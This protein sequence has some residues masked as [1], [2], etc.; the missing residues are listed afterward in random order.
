M[1]KKGKKVKYVKI[2]IPDEPEMLEIKLRLGK[3]LIEDIADELD[4]STSMVKSYRREI[5]NNID[6]SEKEIILGLEAD[7]KNLRKKILAGK[8]K[9]RPRNHTFGVEGLIRG[10]VRDLTNAGKSIRQITEQTGLETST[11]SFHRKNIKEKVKRKYP[12]RIM[13]MTPA[14]IT[15]EKIK[16][17]LKEGKN[18]TQ[19]CEILNISSA[20]ASTHVKKIREKV[21]I[22]MSNA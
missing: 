9:S 5:L 21:R 6:K 3:M 17:L 19:I 12:P 11:I 8:L 4:L 20:T 14:K 7:I 22:K 18:Q 13:N 15:Q 16:R 10:I 1:N 2:D